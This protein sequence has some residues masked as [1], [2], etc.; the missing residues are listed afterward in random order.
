MIMTSAIL[1]VPVVSVS[2]SGFR[3]KPHEGTEGPLGFL[4]TELPLNLEPK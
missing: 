4:D 1:L 3:K 2:G